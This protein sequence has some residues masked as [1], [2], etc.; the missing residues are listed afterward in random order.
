MVFLLTVSFNIEKLQ[1]T[2][3]QHPNWIFFLGDKTKNPQTIVGKWRDIITQSIEELDKLI[4]ATKNRPD[5][6]AWNWGIRTGL[7]DIA[8]LD[9]D[10]E[11]MYYRWLRKFG[12]RAKTVTYRT[13]NKGYRVLFLTS[14]KENDSPYKTSL[15]TE[16]ENKGYAVIGGFAED[17]DGQKQPYQK[18]SQVSLYPD[19]IFCFTSD[20]SRDNTLIADTKT[21]LKYKLVMYDFMQYKCINKTVNTKHIK[22]DHDQRLAILPFMILKKFSDEELH[23]FFRTLYDDKGRDYKKDMT[24][25]QIKSGKE[26]NEKGGKPHPCKPIQQENGTVSVPLYQ[27]FNFDTEECKGC[28]RKT[29][30]A[31]GDKYIVTRSGLCLP[32]M[33]YILD[34][35]NTQQYICPIDTEEVLIYQEPIFVPGK[36]IIF[37]Q[38]EK[39]YEAAM[40]K[41]FASEVY[42]HLQRANF[43]ERDIMNKFTN[44]LPFKNGMFNLKTKNLEKHS[45]ANYLTF[46]YNGE[47]DNKADCPEFKKFVTQILPDIKDQLLLQE[48]MGYCLYP[49]MPLHKLFWFHGKGRNGKGRIILTLEYILGKKNCSQLAISDFSESRRFALCKLC[50]KLLNVSSEPTVSEHGIQTNVLKM[51]TGED[52]IYAEIKG[53]NNRLQFTNIAKPII[54]GNKFPKTNDNTLGW[55]D[56]NECLKFP[57]EFIGKDK[58]L[59]VE[60]KWLPHETNGIILWML[61]GLYRLLEQGEF[62]KSKSALETKAEYMK[63][64]DPFN[65]WLIEDIEF[66]PNTFIESKETH[67]M[68]KNYCFEIGADPVTRTQLYQLLRDT[69]R[70]T[71]IPKKLKGKTERVFLGITQK[72]REDKNLDDEQLDKYAENDEKVA[73]VA[74]VASP[75]TQPT[76]EKVKLSTVKQVWEGVTFATSATSFQIHCFNCGIILE[77][78]EVCTDNDGKKYC[79][80]CRMKIEAKK[81][82]PEGSQ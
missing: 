40:G 60:K 20:I 54:L 56:R 4:T 30:T 57:K 50:G 25:T 79:Q 47:Y 58:I 68:Y 81:K 7:N 5:V 74:E 17:V 39:E 2:K 23:D 21:W 43:V 45:S 59:N 66:N 9:F 31:K 10:W 26:Y 15:H 8:C 82:K 12:D 70:V 19:K 3:Q 55:W 75:H 42:A 34:E 29:A 73:K 24:E 14:E 51:I 67:E 46:H 53:S 77:K 48:I 1:K 35:L 13:A 37:T 76:L 41:N 18:L 32:N 69:P 62:T 71:Y 63:V 38:L 27:Y 11:F 72:N 52:T 64:S 22:L 80:K 33:E 6:D 65:A 28:T 16:F 61:K 49:D 44:G 36:A 78:H